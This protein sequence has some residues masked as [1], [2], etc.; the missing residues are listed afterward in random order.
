MILRFVGVDG[1]T[2]LYTQ[3]QAAG[4]G[5]CLLDR[6]L[7][8]LR[9]SYRVSDRDLAHISRFGAAIVVANHPCGMLEGALFASILRRIR[10][11]TKILANELLARV[12]EIAGAIIAVDVFGGSTR[13]NA[14][15]VSRCLEHL[16]A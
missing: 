8:H 11:D 15:A 1:L 14:S 16:E 13:R 12:P 5:E 7:K 2:S 4:D 3:L 10:P 9:V 6:L